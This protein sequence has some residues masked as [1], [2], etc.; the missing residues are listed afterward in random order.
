MKTR[1]LITYLD[2][3]YVNTSDVYRQSTQVQWLLDENDDEN[4]VL[5]PVKL[6]C[7]IRYSLWGY[8][9]S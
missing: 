3:T 7:N 8:G 5:F 9:G 1:T 4:P 6:T 2:L